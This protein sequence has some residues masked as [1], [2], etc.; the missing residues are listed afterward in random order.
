MTRDLSSLD[1]S[2]PHVPRLGCERHV[3]TGDSNTSSISCRSRASQHPCPSS[4]SQA[5]MSKYTP[6]SQEPEEEVL[7]KSGHSSSDS[8]PPAPRTWLAVLT[9]P[10]VAGTL[11]AFLFVVNIACITVLAQQ[12]RNVH[13]ALQPHL[14]FTDTRAL[15]RPDPYDSLARMYRS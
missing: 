8:L 1:P 14:D 15:P 3:R 9:S 13:A 4:R 6:L 12:V 2:S 11:V 7:L 5:A 10:V